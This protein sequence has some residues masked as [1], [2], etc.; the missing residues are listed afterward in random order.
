MNAP[1]L[2]GRTALVTDAAHGVGHETA[3]G[4]AKLGAAVTLVAGHAE[5]GIEAVE[6]IRCASGNPDVELV[7][8]DLSSRAEVRALADHF[9][10]RHRRLD[11]LVNHAA[12]AFPERGETVDGVEATLAAAHLSPAL[13]TYLLLP[14]LRESAPARIVNVAPAASSR[15]RV[16]WDDLQ[17]TRGYRAADAYAHARLLNLLWTGELARRVRGTGIT[18]VA[19]DAGEIRPAGTGL[20]ALWRRVGH[21]WR[22][23]TA[24]DAA[25]GA[26][27]AATS[28]DVQSGAFLDARGRPARPSRRARDGEA[29]LRAW[30][31][32]AEMLGIDVDTVAGRRRRATGDAE[33][34]TAPRLVAAGM[35][36]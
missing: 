32:T 13:L 27:V 8:A 5:R 4:L 15:A 30:T 25:R 3:L 29:A 34:F 9:A 33:R 17:S 18:V 16:R 10:A 11:L 28:R 21:G 20:R 23:G 6:A 19:A 14:L 1:P 26:I 2:V 35:A 12:G 7:T 24:E 31:V 22:N 36:A